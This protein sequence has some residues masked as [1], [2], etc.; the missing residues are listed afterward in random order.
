MVTHRLRAAVGTH[1]LESSWASVALLCRAACPSAISRR[2]RAVVVD[3]VKAKPWGSWPHVIA[4]AGEIVSP[5]VADGDAFIDVQS[6][7]YCFNSL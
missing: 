4:K 2:V 3:A 7:Y 1:R 6:Y 5:F